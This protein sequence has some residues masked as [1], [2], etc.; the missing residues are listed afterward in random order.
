MSFRQ[1]QLLITEYNVV[2]KQC[3]MGVIVA[4]CIFSVIVS[5]YM[6]VNSGEN[7][8]VP[9]LL[10]MIIIF[11]VC[12]FLTAVGMR[13]PASV[14]AISRRVIANTKQLFNPKSTFYNIC[15]VRKY[16]KSF[17]VFKIQFFSGNFFEEATPLV[18]WIFVQIRL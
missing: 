10:V 14:Y 16:W 8:S 9:L 15:W 13:Y 7:L 6:I 11:C 12:F 1:I 4:T 2:H 17:P 3:A 5:A 18:L